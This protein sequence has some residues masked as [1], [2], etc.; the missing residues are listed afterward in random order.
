MS[1]DFGSYNAVSA[2]PVSLQNR[3][4]ALE[5]ELRA[6]SVALHNA[7]AECLRLRRHNKHLNYNLKRTLNKNSTTMASPPSLQRT[8][9]QIG[10]LL[11]QNEDLVVQADID[12]KM[13]EF[14]DSQVTSLETQVRQLIHL[15]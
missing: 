13:K 14:L 9:E 10:R 4:L 3:V 1:G 12:R 8:P 15:M 6:E 11:K 2:D 7:E 5:E